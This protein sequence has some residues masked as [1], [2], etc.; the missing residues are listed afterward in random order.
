MPYPYPYYAADCGTDL[1]DVVVGEGLD[2]ASRGFDWRL[3]GDG[4][5]LLSFAAREACE[6]VGPWN[7]DG[8][9]PEEVEARLVVDSSYRHRESESDVQVSQ[10]AQTTPTANVLYPY[11]ATFSTSGYGYW[12]SSYGNVY[13]AGPTGGPTGAPGGPEEPA[14]TPDQVVELTVRGLAP[15]LDLAC[16]YRRA[17]GTWADLPLLGVGD[18]RPALPE[19]FEEISFY[20]DRLVAPPASCGATAP[21]QERDYWS[22]S[23]QRGGAPGGDPTGEPGGG[24]STG[25]EG[26]EGGEGG[27]GGEKGTEEDWGWISVSAG[28]R[29]PEDPEW[30]G[31]FDGTSL[32]WSNDSHFFSIYGYDRGQGFEDEVLFA[33]ARALDPDFDPDTAIGESQRSV[34][35]R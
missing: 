3:P 23:F 29:L 8:S 30:P 17:S 32:S 35:E 34:P 5:A 26:N 4:F 21:N 1:L 24:G 11:A 27:E 14:L 16:F 25:G 13:V 33:I 19:K 15:E 9:P 20:L 7:E 10:R 22:A 6:Y 28:S 31:T 2:L 12:V 18:P